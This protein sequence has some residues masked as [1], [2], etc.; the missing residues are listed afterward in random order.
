[1]KYRV[2]FDQETKRHRHR[3]LDIVCQSIDDISETILYDTAVSLQ[4]H[5]AFSADL[6]DIVN[7]VILRDLDDV[8]IGEFG[9]G[10]DRILYRL[11]YENV[12][13][14]LDS[15][16]SQLQVNVCNINE[17]NLLEDVHKGDLDEPKENVIDAIRT[18]KKVTDG[19]WFSIL[20]CDDIY[21]SK[22]QQEQIVQILKRK[23]VKSLD[24]LEYT[25][26]WDDNFIKAKLDCIIGYIVKSN[27]HFGL[28]R[29]DGSVCTDVG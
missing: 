8:P 21:I 24:L 4:I 13:K 14:N 20:C 12:Y 18:I 5:E 19:Q 27:W 11:F 3:F 9:R 25:V 17:I 2:F 22:E 1:M 15:F 6:D 7:K 23:L 10:N 29:E 28:K 26:S 16:I